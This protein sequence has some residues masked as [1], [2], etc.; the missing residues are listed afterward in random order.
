M[1]GT[2]KMLSSENIIFLL[3]SLVKVD[4]SLKKLLSNI[5]PDFQFKR[6]FLVII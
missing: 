1:T 3:L 5:Y 2:F 6:D 4:D